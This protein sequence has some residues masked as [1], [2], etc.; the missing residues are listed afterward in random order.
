MIFLLIAGTSKV[1][2]YVSSGSS[3]LDRFWRVSVVGAEER[4]Q[5]IGVGEALA[6]A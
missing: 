5:L 3:S 4:E 2:T 6:A 1:V